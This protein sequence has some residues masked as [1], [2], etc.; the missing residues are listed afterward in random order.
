MGD[1]G[2]E[3]VDQPLMEDVVVVDMPGMEDV[4][5]VDMPVICPP[6]C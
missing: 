4:V 3:D 6:I 1:E 2:I 5:A